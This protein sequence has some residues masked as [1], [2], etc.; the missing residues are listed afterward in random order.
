VIDLADEDENIINVSAAISVV[1]LESE[2]SVSPLDT[3]SVEVIDVD[4]EGDTEGGDEGNDDFDDDSDV[5]IWD[6]SCF[7]LDDGTEARGNAALAKRS[8]DIDPLYFGFEK[9]RIMPLAS[10]SHKF[11]NVPFA[12]GNGPEFTKAY[13]RDVKIL[14]ESLPYGILVKG[15]ED[16]MVT[17]IKMNNKPFNE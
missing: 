10:S 11:Y 16:K 6:D 17:Y 12:P 9:F 14:K 1:D 13:Q 4:D 7:E 2:T 15:F 8:D 3:G 5:E